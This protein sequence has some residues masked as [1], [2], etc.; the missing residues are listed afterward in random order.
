MY[1]HFKAKARLRVDRQRVRRD[2]VLA[3]RLVR[4]ADAGQVQLLKQSV[5]QRGLLTGPQHNVGVLRG[6]FRGHGFLHF[7]YLAGPPKAAVRDTTE[8]SVPPPARTSLEYMC[9][10]PHC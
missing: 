1:G 4:I 6:R 2:F 5:V 8:Y 9:A 7:G 10:T 3:K